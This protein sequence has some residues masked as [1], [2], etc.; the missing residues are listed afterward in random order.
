MY[1]FHSTPSGQENLVTYTDQTTTKGNKSNRLSPV[2]NWRLV[3]GL[4]WILPMIFLLWL[5]FSSH[6]IGGTAWCFKKPCGV[7][8]YDSESEVTTNALID[9][10][11]K[12]NHNL[13]GTL[14]FAAKALEVWFMYIASSLV[15]LVAYTLAQRPGG[16]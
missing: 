14:Q 15:Y 5:N 4:L 16:T 13:L 9:R 8:Q 1:R 7:I 2:L 12:A 10:Y 6:V 11:E 3:F